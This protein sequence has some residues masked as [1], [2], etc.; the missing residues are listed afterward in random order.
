MERRASLQRLETRECVCVVNSGTVQEV[1]MAEQRQR[2]LLW[3]WF[4]CL[5]TG[6]CSL[7]DRVKEQR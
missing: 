3:F 1:S 6:A 2:D 7:G 4:V 5:F